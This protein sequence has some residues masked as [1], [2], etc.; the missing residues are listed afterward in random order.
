MPAGSTYTPIA[1][2]TLG[3]AQSSY[4]F[5]S[6]PSTYTDLILVVAGT[7]STGSDLYAQFNS[8]TGNNYGKILVYSVDGA[9]HGSAAYAN[10]AQIGFANL[11]TVQ[12]NSIMHVMNYANTTTFKSVLSRSTNG[13]TGLQMNVG[14]WRST[15]AINAIKVYPAAGNLSSGFVLTLYGIASA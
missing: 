9:G 8:D 6:I 14:C 15:S 3:S 1:T 7:L 10:V 11:S 12:G 5:S 13:G 2:T 4:T